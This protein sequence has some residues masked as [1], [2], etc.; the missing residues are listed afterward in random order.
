MSSEGEGFGTHEIDRNDV[1]VS[2]GKI[3]SDEEEILI[4]SRN[5]SVNPNVIGDIILRANSDGS[6]LRI[7]DIGTVKR[8]STYKVGGSR[9]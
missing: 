5:R 1:D 8:K 7:R 2:A 9:K 6:Y 3:R 4:R